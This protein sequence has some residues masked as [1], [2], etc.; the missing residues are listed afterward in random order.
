MEGP[1]SSPENQTWLHLRHTTLQQL[2]WVSVKGIWVTRKILSQSRRK[3]E[4][5]TTKKREKYATTTKAFLKWKTVVD[6]CYTH[7]TLF[8]HHSFGVGYFFFIYLKYIF[9]NFVT[10]KKKRRD[11]LIHTFFGKTL[12]GEKWAEYKSGET[13]EVI[14]DDFAARSLHA[15][16]VIIRGCLCTAIF[17]GI[18]DAFCR[19][20]HA[21]I[22]GRVRWESVG[23]GNYVNFFT[24]FNIECP[25]HK[26]HF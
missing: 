3:K 21:P 1:Q 19:G 6:H 13:E 4:K 25:Y 14:F 7:N 11:G 10:K 8:L 9:Y 24:L 17:V 2:S 16:L 12:V 18:C 5:Y 15:R 26:P 23:D 22:F 20:S